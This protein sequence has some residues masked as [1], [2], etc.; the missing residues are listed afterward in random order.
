[1]QILITG[2]KDLAMFFR[3]HGLSNLQMRKGL[4]FFLLLAFPS[5]EQEMGRRWLMREIWGP[6][7][8]GK[9]VVHSDP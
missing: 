4:T 8:V 9:F 7:S 5:T 6:F 2:T 1:M 3:A